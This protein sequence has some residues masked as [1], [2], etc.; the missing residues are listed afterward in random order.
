MPRLCLACEPSVHARGSAMK[1]GASVFLRGVLVLIGLGA[2]GL[3]LWEPHLEGRNAGATL[4]RIYFQD[5]F[6]AYAYVAAIPFFVGLYAS[7]S[8]CRATA[9]ITRAAWPS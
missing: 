7:S 9:T 2:F 3:L 1:F 4:Y 6:L 8:S 5:P